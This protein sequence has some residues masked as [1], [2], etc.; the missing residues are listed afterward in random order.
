MR[1]GMKLAKC[2]GVARRLQ[3][4]PT[5]DRGQPLIAGTTKT[6]MLLR[7]G[8]THWPSRGS[9]DLRLAATPSPAS[10]A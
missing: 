8:R 7:P 9:V 6:L 4:V 5:R 10:S 1:R 3:C 2:V